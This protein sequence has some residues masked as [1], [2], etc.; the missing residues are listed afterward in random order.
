MK[1][2]KYLTITIVIVCAVT[3]VFIFSLPSSIFNVPFIKKYNTAIL[4]PEGWGF[5][6]KNPRER[7]LL[8]YKIEY[9]DTIGIVYKNASFK[10]YLGLSKKNRR[11]YLESNILISDAYKNLIWYTEMQKHPKS[12]K[13]KKNDRIQFIPIGNYMIIEREILPWSFTKY[14]KNYKNEY[15][16]AYITVY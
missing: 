11:I 1:L 7:S 2:I 16:I 5:F 15:K 9:T 8:L 3:I 12:I 10:N 6:T 14:K 4:M 13:V